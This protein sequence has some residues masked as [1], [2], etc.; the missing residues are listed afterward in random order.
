[1]HQAGEWL[2]RRLFWHDG[3]CNGESAAARRRGGKV[4]GLG[5]AGGWN[6]AC[7]STKCLEV[8]P[9]DGLRGCLHS[10]GAL[11]AASRVARTRMP[12]WTGRRERG[13]TEGKCERGGVGAWLC[14]HGFACMASLAG[15]AL[16]RPCVRLFLAAQPRQQRRHATLISGRSRHAPSRWSGSMRAAATQMPPMPQSPSR[17]A[18]CQSLA[19]RRRCRRRARAAPSLASPATEALRSAEAPR[20]AKAPQAAEARP[21]AEARRG[22]GRVPR[23]TG[24]CLR[25]W[26]SGAAA[27]MTTGR[28]S[29][30]DGARA[31]RRTAACA[32]P[33]D[34]RLQSKWCPSTRSRRS[35]RHVH[36]GTRSWRCGSSVGTPTSCRLVSALT[37]KTPPPLT[38][39]LSHP[40]RK[41]RTGPQSAHTP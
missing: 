21:A 22:C 34:G 13:R 3:Q 17:R 7:R 1:M 39:P 24:C 8:L 32:S 31:E 27:G 19:R 9:V 4:G 2:S 40:K 38:T 30:S 23:P 12:G 28:G 35:T 20:A 10:Q 6:L 16:T 36:C 5:E 26:C 33:T 41:S 25:T 18:P 29:C 37:I 15:F 14:L 11:P